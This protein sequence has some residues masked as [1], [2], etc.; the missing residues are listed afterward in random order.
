MS[1][2]EIKR[3]EERFQKELKNLIDENINITKDQVIIIRFILS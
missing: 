3:F 1:N 2:D